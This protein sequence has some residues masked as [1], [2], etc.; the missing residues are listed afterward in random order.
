M[1]GKSNVANCRSWCRA[2]RA[3]RAVKDRGMT[4]G[5]RKNTVKGNNL[6]SY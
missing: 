1:K 3:C 6:I 4:Q 2:C 5:V